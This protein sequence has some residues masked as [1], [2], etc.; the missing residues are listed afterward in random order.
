MKIPVLPS[1]LPEVASVIHRTA[2][3][4]IQLVTPY[5][6]GF[7]VRKQSLRIVDRFAALDQYKVIQDRDQTLLV[8]I[9]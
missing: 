2:E 4:L 8:H 7:K 5:I 6:Q 1:G 9:S 3:V